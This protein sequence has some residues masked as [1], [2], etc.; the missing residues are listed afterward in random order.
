MNRFTG[1]FV[2]LIFAFTLGWGQATPAP[3]NGAPAATP[4]QAAPTPP[5]DVTGCMTQWF[6]NFSV[7]SANNAQSWQIKGDGAALWN[8]EN[9]VVTI[10]GLADPKASSPTMY[11]QNIQD[12]G[13]SCGTAAASNAATVQ[14]GAAGSTTPT[15][16]AETGSTT[17]AGAATAA[18]GATG[19]PA[20]TES[21]QQPGGGVAQPSTTTT[22]P[23]TPQA[24]AAPQQGGVSGT[25]A[26]SSM[27]PQSNTTAENKG[28]P[29]AGTPQNSGIANNTAQQQPADDNRIFDGCIIGSMNN[30]QFKSNGK[31]Y[32]LQGNTANLNTMVN[33]QVELTGE[34]FNGKAIQV[35]GARDLGGACKGK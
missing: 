14:P 20:G 1:V 25:A 21:Q 22:Q 11:A 10:K 27:T 4:A 7:A 35:N 17:G 32:H 15:A 2:V 30:Y 31:T 5:A 9:H 3:Q 23:Q 34:D 6:G 8:H 12:T 18:P 33:H 24:S 19:T 29:T 26:G 28:V 16:N 13:Q